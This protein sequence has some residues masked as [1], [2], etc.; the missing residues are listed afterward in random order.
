MGLRRSGV[1]PERSRLEGHGDTCRAQREQP[2]SYSGG[3]LGFG[4]RVT[5][6]G[7][8]RELIV[9][10]GGHV[11]LQQ[12]HIFSD[13]V[14]SCSVLLVPPKLVVDLYDVGEFVS[15]V[16]LESRQREGQWKKKHSAG[17]RYIWHQGPSVNISP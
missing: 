11:E 2:V 4:P 13:D 14:S 16:I 9:H 12:L 10:H 3:P 5:Y 6:T 7:Q 17:E 15:Q 1:C 8:P